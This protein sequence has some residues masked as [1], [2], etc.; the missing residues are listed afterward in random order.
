MIST[1]CTEVA[2]T[3]S[4]TPSE[5]FCP[6]TKILAKC[7]KCQLSIK[8]TL[9]INISGPIINK[10]L[11][12]CQKHSFGDILSTFDA[13]STFLIDSVCIL[14][15]TPKIGKLH[16]VLQ[17]FAVDKFQ[18]CYIESHCKS[19]VTSANDFIFST[20]R[21]YLHSIYISLLVFKNYSRS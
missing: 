18:L 8:N 20:H 21:A 14:R 10:N 15:S 4:T 11:H 2:P 7:F 1:F 6:Q 5:P 12:Y 3:Y 9:Q 16:V 17:C 19:N 13:N